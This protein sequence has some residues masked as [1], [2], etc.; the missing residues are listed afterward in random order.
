MYIWAQQSYP[1]DRDKLVTRNCGGRVLVR[2]RP[3]HSSLS[4]VQ[5]HMCCNSWGWP[6]WGWDLQSCRKSCK[7]QG[8]EQCPS[9]S[10]PSR[11]WKGYDLPGGFWA[12]TAVLL[13]GL[14]GLFSSLLWFLDVSLLS[15]WP[16]TGGVHK[17]LGQQLPYHGA[18]TYLNIWR[19][20]WDCKISM[21]KAGRRLHRDP[22]QSFL[23]YHYYCL[24]KLGRLCSSPEIWFVTSKKEKKKN[25]ENS[26]RQMEHQTL[27]QSKKKKIPNNNNN[28]NGQS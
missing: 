19:H 4:T 5:N 8:K 26:S 2:Q 20:C 14:L 21:G 12:S 24:P 27:K 3:W 23:I 10:C 15:L 13:C 11:W 25:Y 28:N 16:S 7:H 9:L 6:G 22:R 1:Q 18:C 17:A